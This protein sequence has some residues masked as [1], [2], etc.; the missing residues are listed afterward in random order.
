[1]RCNRCDPKAGSLTVMRISVIGTGYLGATHAACMADLGH[2][3]IGFDV[4][5]D[6]VAS[7]AAGTVPFHEPG[8][9]QVLQRALS[10]GRLRFTTAIADVAAQADVHFLCV[11]TPQSKDSNAADMSQVNG[12]IDLLAPHLDRPCL[13]VGKSTVPVG[14]A[15]RLA[16]QLRSTS[17]AS[18]DVHLAWNPEFLREGHAVADTVAPDR[19]VIGVT[20]PADEAT[21]RQVYAQLLANDVPLIVADLPTS[22]LVKASANAFL[23]TKISF[24][25]AIAELCEATGADITVLADAIGRD[26]RI[27]RQ[28]LNAGLG[29]GGGCLPKDIRAFRARATELGIGESLDFLDDVDAINQRCRTRVVAVALSLTSQQLGGKPVTILGAAFKPDSDDVRDSPAL[30]VAAELIE[31]GAQVTIFDPVAN[32][33][34]STRVPTATYADTLYEALA[35]AELVLLL[36]EWKQFQDLDPIKTKSQV[37]TPLMIDARNVLDPQ[38]W[39]NAGWTIHS[40]GRGTRHP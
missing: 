25:N 23:A 30:A 4:D 28:F 15:Q 17:P 36:T 34:A 10:S 8:L 40:L 18:T 2:E 39:A 22:E 6:K 31:H 32:Q 24:I 20:D 11:G 35:G 19:L 13:V 16:D 26:E 3:V 9:D 21:L 38:Q 1:M 5:P 14:T 27:G 37:A 12:A 7:L 29:F 33:T